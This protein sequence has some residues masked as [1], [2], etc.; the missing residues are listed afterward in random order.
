MKSVLIIV[1]LLICFLQAFPQK[2]A[3]VGIRVGAA[4]YWG[5]LENVTYK[6]EITA[7]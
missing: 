1:S 5:D 3:D 7:L 6:K 2:S 4:L